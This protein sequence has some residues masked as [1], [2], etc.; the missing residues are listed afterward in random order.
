M[1]DL[2]KVDGASFIKVLDT[3]NV[4]DKSNISLVD[5]FESYIEVAV[6]S[7]NVV[8]ANKL[9]SLIFK[10]FQKYGDFDDQVKSVAQ[11]VSDI[12][13]ATS[14]V[15]T[16]ID[17]DNK[18]GITNAYN[19][20]KTYEEKLNE[21][22]E[23]IY[24]D[25]LTKVF[26]RKYLLGKELNA[27]MN[28]K[29]SGRIFYL[30]IENL[31]S[32]DDLYGPIVTKSVLKKFAQSVNKAL[33]PVDATLIRYDDNEFIILSSEERAED[34]QNTL[35]LLHR[36]FEIKKFKLSGEKTLAFNFTIHEANF[37]EGKAF[38]ESYQSL[39]S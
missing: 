33:E 16:A 1:S 26:N 9:R 3:K 17:E 36:T 4:G 39:L 22:E 28:F 13:G 5:I 14:E 24:V 6:A 37:E 27:D 25:E 30:L 15:I 21:M 18:E 8:P 35:K 7:T 23:G 12:S 38:E 10:Q 32:I 31:E 11:T 34:I 19:K 2:F 20:L 29:T